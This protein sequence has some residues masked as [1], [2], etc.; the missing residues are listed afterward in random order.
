MHYNCNTTRRELQD[1]IIFIFLKKESNVKYGFSKVFENSKTSNEFI[2]CNVAEFFYSKS[3]QR[4][5]GQSR[6][7]WTLKALGHI[8]TSALKALGHLGIQILRHSKGTLALE[9]LY[10]HSWNPPSPK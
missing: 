7:T 8:G 9:A 3:T 2:S 6:G 10:L 4:E 1:S 5:I